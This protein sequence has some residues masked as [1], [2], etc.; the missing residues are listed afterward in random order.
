MP[1]SRS[2]AAGED[3]LARSKSIWRASV[4][5]LSSRSFRCDQAYCLFSC[6]RPTCDLTSLLGAAL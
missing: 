5:R 1:A 2:M 6:C 3:S 4:A